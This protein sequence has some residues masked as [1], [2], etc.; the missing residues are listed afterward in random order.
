MRDLQAIIHSNNIAAL[1]AKVANIEPKAQFTVITHDDVKSTHFV[2][3]QDCHNYMSLCEYNNTIHAH[4]YV[5]DLLG[6]PLHTIKRV[7]VNILHKD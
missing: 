1:Q 2:A 3:V 7:E 4:A 6:I 5:S